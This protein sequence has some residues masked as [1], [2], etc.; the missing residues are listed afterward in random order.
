MSRESRMFAGMLLI[1][2]IFLTLLVVS[3]LHAQVQ[4]PDTP[5]AMRRVA[6]GI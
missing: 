2:R 6:A 1:A 5:Q 4:L 3:L